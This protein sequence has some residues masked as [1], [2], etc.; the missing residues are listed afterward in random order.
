MS[1]SDP[2]SK[3]DLIDTSADIKR[4]M[5]KCFC[6]PGNVDENGLLAFC[7]FVAFPIQKGKGNG[8]FKDFC[9]ESLQN[10]SSIDRINTVAQCALPTMK[11]YTMTLPHR[12]YIRPI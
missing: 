1:A 9:A 5:K 3:I 7:K 11:H 4:K 10:S 2:D 8:F 6:E 12:K